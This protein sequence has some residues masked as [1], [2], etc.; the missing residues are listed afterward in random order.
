MKYQCRFGHIVD[1]RLCKYHEVYCTPIEEDAPPRRRP[2]PG[3]NSSDGWGGALGVLFLGLV[4]WLGYI[5]FSRPD[6]SSSLQLVA[7]ITIAPDAEKRIAHIAVTRLRN[8]G[9][10]IA[11]SMSLELWVAPVTPA[12]GNPPNEVKIGEVVLGR[13]LPA[14]S[15]LDNVES[16][17]PIKKVPYTSQ[18][19]HLL[20]RLRETYKN[21]YY[22]SIDWVSEP[23]TI[24]D[25]V[26]FADAQ[27]TR[28]WERKTM[29]IE[30]GLC[31]LLIVAGGA[32]L[33]I[34]RRSRSMREKPAERAE[35]SA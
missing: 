23:Y 14:K 34:R 31:A 24:E 6:G 22:K 7:P 8:S 11:G 27:W 13:E 32:W 1:S 12:A 2:R 16:D 33:M 21:E 4:I 3:S 17:I 35:P 30:A 25:P 10:G 29:W 28:W 5:Y 18:P 19:C 15:Y 20:L 9:S 26:V